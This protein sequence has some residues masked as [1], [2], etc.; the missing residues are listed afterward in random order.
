MDACIRAFATYH[1]S[2]GSAQPDDTRR[3]ASNECRFLSCSRHRTRRRGAWELRTR[4]FGMMFVVSSVDTHGNSLVLELER[5]TPPP[6][7]SAR[8]ERNE[9][10]LALL[11]LALTTSL[12]TAAEKGFAVTLLYSNGAKKTFTILRSNPDR[13]APHAISLRNGSLVFIRQAL[14]TDLRDGDLYEAATVF[15]GDLR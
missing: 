14:H 13:P 2:C 15:K 12:A 11:F 10:T 4:L 3:R 7:N 8:K 6:D 9:T 1:T 5:C